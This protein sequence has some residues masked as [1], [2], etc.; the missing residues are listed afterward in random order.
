[1]ASEEEKAEDVPRMYTSES[2]QEVKSPKLNRF[3]ENDVSNRINRD[4]ESMAIAAGAKHAA[5]KM[6]HGNQV[7]IR[8]SSL[9]TDKSTNSPRSKIL[10]RG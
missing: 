3:N 1:M 8:S 10:S 7:I 4:F 2:S 9:Y 5:A 6:I